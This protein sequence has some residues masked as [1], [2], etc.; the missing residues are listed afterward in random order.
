[1][2]YLKQLFCPHT[3]KEASDV[4]RRDLYKDPFSETYCCIRCGKRIYTQK[5]PISYI[6]DLY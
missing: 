6:E 3:W 2:N 4:Q 5:I 1:M